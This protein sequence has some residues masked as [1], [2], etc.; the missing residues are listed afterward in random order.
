MLKNLSTEGVYV[1]EWKSSDS[2][3]GME[4]GTQEKFLGEP[5]YLKACL[6][7]PTWFKVL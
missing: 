5:N 4:I 3:L 7:F 2:K 6:T 1:G